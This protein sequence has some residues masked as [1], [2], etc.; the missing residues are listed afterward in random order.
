MGMKKIKQGV[1]KY[2]NYQKPLNLVNQQK[3]HGNQI[4]S[5]KNWII[6]S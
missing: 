6:S 3:K 1:G 4:S 2:L 5:P